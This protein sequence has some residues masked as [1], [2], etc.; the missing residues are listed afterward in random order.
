MLALHFVEGRDY[1]WCFHSQISDVRQAIIFGLNASYFHCATSSP[2]QTDLVISSDCWVEAVEDLLN[3]K[4][5]APTHRD[6]NLDILSSH[7]YWIKEMA[8][9]NPGGRV[10]STNI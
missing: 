5:G 8:I 6:L 7:R 1:W 9:H 3:S 4:T 10:R 2:D